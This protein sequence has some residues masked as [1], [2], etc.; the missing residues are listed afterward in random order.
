M[1]GAV[2]IVAAVPTMAPATQKAKI[3]ETANKEDNIAPWRSPAA[4]RRARR[5]TQPKP[6]FS[7]EFPL[8]SCGGLY[9][10][11]S[12]AEEPPLRRASGGEGGAHAQRGRVRW[13][14]AGA[15]EP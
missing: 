5:R 7:R 15:R 6:Q 8:E 9:A 13:T 12:A 2:T 3:A 1:N 14:L 11:R 4:E 10:S